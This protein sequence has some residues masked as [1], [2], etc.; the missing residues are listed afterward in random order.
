M[1]HE[2]GGCVALAC[3][4]LHLARGFTDYE[5]GIHWAQ[6]QMQSGVTGINTPRMYNPTKQ[7]REQDPKG[8]FI[9]RWVPELAAVSDAWIHAPWQMPALT[10]RMCGVCIGRDYPAPVVEHDSAIRAAKQRLQRVRRSPGARA[11][12]G[13]VYRKHGSR[14][15]RRQRW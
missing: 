12:A 8:E 14:R 9:R 2:D 6:V 4:G 10:Q 7:A 11:E 1:G 13:R 3:L 15:G 5:P